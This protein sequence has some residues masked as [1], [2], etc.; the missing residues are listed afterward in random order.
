MP[1]PER[2]PGAHLPSRRGPP[3]KLIPT[4]RRRSARH[5]SAVQKG[6]RAAGGLAGHDAAGAGALLRALPP[7]AA[8]HERRPVSTHPH[9]RGGPRPE[10]L[11]Y[12]FWPHSRA[13]F[14]GIHSQAS[15][16]AELLSRF[17]W[18]GAAG[19]SKDAECTPS[20]CH[21]RGWTSTSVLAGVQ[22]PQS[23]GQ[24]S[25]WDNQGPVP[26]VCSALEGGGHPH[27]G[28]HPVPRV[29]MV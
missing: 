28:T 2:S 17:I 4:C 26:L 9:P 5:L 14:I 3:P 27:L 7:G 25:P 24:S 1:A 13:Q 20:H 11:C 19:G 10:P 23:S 15:R 29:A 6:V 8:G 22:L 16:T 18:G 12:W 21:G